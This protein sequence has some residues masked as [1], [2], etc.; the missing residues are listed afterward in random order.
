MVVGFGNL[1][2]VSEFHTLN[3][4]WQLRR[5]VETAPSLPCTIYKLEDH[6][7]YRFV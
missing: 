2:P 3:D 5:P 4:L 7:E 1:K 6:R